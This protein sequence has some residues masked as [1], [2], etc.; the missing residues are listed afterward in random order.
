M[1]VEMPKLDGFE[2]TLQIRTLERGT[3]RHLPIVA[4]TARVRKS[5]PC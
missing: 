1:D 3:G 5:V 4:T 2:A